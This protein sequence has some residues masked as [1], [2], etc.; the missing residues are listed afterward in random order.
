MNNPDESITDLYIKQ[1]T[2]NLYAALHGVTITDDPHGA[3]R[4]LLEAVD[5]FA[6]LNDGW[7]QTRFDSYDKWL[8]ARRD[9]VKRLAAARARFVLVPQE[10]Q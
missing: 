6:M 2:A 1:N 3:V 9:S 4:G 7:A 10:A 8:D 5:E